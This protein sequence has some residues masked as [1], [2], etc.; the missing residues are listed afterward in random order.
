MEDLCC[1][2]YLP[3]EVFMENK[4]LEGEVKYCFA[5]MW[6]HLYT[7]GVSIELE[8]CAAEPEVLYCTHEL[9]EM[10]DRKAEVMEEPDFQSLEERGSNS[11]KKFFQVSSITSKREHA[12][13][14]KCDL[15]YDRSI[16]QLRLDIMRRKR[17]V[18]FTGDV[19]CLKLG[20]K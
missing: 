7:N 9:Q 17:A 4:Q 11:R 13:V 10:W 12:K 3:V 2:V 6:M 1:G 15:C 16:Q 8:F 19:K 14:G 5:L 20:K 18:M